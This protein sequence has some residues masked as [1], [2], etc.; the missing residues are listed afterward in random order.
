MYM[1][2]SDRKIG[3]LDDS[4]VPSI[5]VLLKKL[6]HFHV[7]RC[8]YVV[9]R[10]AKVFLS[11]PKILGLCNLPNVSDLLNESK[12]TEK[13]EFHL[14][15]R[16]VRVCGLWEGKNV[17]CSCH[18]LHNNFRHGSLIRLGCI[19]NTEIRWKER[20][21]HTQE[22]TYIPFPQ[23][24]KVP[25]SPHSNTLIVCQYFFSTIAEYTP[26]M[27]GV[28]QR[29]QSFLKLFSI[30]WFCC[31]PGSRA[32]S[33]LPGSHLFVF[34]GFFFIFLKRVCW[35]YTRG[36]NIFWAFMEWGKGKAA[37]KL[38]RFSVAASGSHFLMLWLTTAGFV[39]FWHT[40]KIVLIWVGY[41][42]N[43]TCEVFFGQEL[44]FSV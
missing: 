38:C 37:H 5:T 23:P 39:C 33:V 40:F 3:L 18:Y 26:L 34:V 30:W 19:G 31:V 17:V 24:L 25:L 2:L 42:I 41:R 35:W 14:K 6:L 44:N 16:S 9:L 7:T 43:S 8:L 12:W 29:K 11:I 1:I 4:L 13:Q 36:L 32:L 28:L 27:L 21:T 15:S 20:D 10:S 22:K